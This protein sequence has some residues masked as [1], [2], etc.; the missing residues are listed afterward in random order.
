MFYYQRQ[1]PIINN[2]YSLFCLNGYYVKSYYV[3]FFATIIN[4]FGSHY[5]QRP[6]NEAG[7]FSRKDCNLCDGA[8]EF[9]DSVYLSSCSG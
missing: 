8:M 6:A 3:L 4:F 9:V 5:L 2:P 7:M 1:P